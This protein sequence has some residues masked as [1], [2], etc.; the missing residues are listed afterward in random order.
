VQLTVGV[1]AGDA[2]S[3]AA[4]SLAE[5]VREAVDARSRAV[6]ALSGGETPWLM[7]RDLRER[8]LPWDRLHVAQVDERVVPD[9]DPRRNLSRLRELLVE[10][11]PLSADRL[12]AMP[13][14]A[15]DLDRAAA[16][17]QSALERVAGRPIVL[18]V[19]QLGLGTDGHTAS[20]VPGDRVLDVQDRDVALTGD[21]QGSRRMTL[22]F[23]A[24]TRARSRLW[25]VTGSAK[26]ARLADLLRGG[27]T[28]PALRLPRQGAWVFADR[29]AKPA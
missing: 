3:K 6:I 14:T 11:G 4:E 17:Y 24:L 7:I 20:L 18:D 12:I 22:T 8:D 13:V 23:P 27:G 1:D 21:Y 10:S 26:A 19:V 5:S 25:L 15:P 2:A 16:D 29:A 9:D 28:A